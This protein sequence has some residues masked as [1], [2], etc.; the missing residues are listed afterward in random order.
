MP[1]IRSLKNMLQVF[2]AVVDAL[3]ELKLFNALQEAEKLKGS[4]CFSL[5]VLPLISC[6]CRFYLGEREQANLVTQ[7][8]QFE[9]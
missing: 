9:C 6:L 4:M 1:P 8:V 2:Q 5:T 7:L 3:G